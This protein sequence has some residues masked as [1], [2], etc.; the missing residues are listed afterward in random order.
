MKKPYIKKIDVR[1]DITVWEVDGIYVRKNIDRE[2]TN[3]GQHF[4]FKKIPKNEF[5]LDKENSPG[6][7]NFFIDH[8][9]VEHKLMAKGK[10]YIYSI[11]EADKLEKKERK[12]SKLFVK[13]H[14]KGKKEIIDKIHKKLLKKYS[15]KIKIWIISGE[16]VRD[17]YNI[18]FTEGGHDKVYKF[19]PENE[20]W[21]DDDL[22]PRDRKFVLLH[23]LHERNLM[24]K[25]LCYN[26]AHK[27]SSRIE[28]FA[29][30]N[31]TKLDELIKKESL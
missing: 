2:F 1:G 10:N 4:R 5:W 28:Y 13:I 31:P 23:E 15:G 12:K 29:R 19:V 22:S 24:A 16:L 11:D 26:D 7:E 9:L 14:K 17:L 21:L 18:D 27:S 8:L 20:V 3:F 6:E 25:G 30:H